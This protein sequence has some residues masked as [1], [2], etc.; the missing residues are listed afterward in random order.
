MLTKRVHK[1]SF[2]VF[3]L[4]IEDLSRE[5]GRSSRG[6][7]TVVHSNPEQ[8]RNNVLFLL[9]SAAGIVALSVGAAWGW[10]LSDVFYVTQRTFRSGVSSLSDALNT[11]QNRLSEVKSR[12][13]SRIAEIS[14][15]QDE[16]AAVQAA[17]REQLTRVGTDVEVMQSQ[18]GQVYH[19]VLDLDESLSEIGTHQRQSLRGIYILCK[20]VAELASNSNIKS[21]EE[22][23][24]FTRSPLWHN[25]LRPAGLQS[26]L[27]DTDAIEDNLDWPYSRRKLLNDK[28]SMNFNFTSKMNEL[29]LNSGNRLDS[30]GIGGFSFRPSGVDNDRGIEQKERSIDYVGKAPPVESRWK[31]L[32]MNMGFSLHEKNRNFKIPHDSVSS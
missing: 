27:D 6:G 14:R 31:E 2:L 3:H 8:Y 15:K 11:L 1:C 17:M 5:I 26:I 10:R 9:T 30:A 22:L 20:A 28:L 29:P 18:V 25:C 13:Q 12:L 21:K 23:L 4:Q 19:A 32:P 16:S 7:V 24:Q